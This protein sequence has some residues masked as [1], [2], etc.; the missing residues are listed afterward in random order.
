M[1]HA[2]T[3]A[4]SPAVAKTQEPQNKRKGRTQHPDRVWV[5]AETL[6]R[7]SGWIAEASERLQGV[8]ITRSDLV[9]YLVMSHADALSATE[10][11]EVEARY[12]DPLKHGLWAMGE[13]KAALA[14]GEKTTL[15]EILAARKPPASAIPRPRARKSDTSQNSTNPD[16]NA[17]KKSPTTEEGTLISVEKSSEQ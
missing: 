5:D 17:Q 4:T 6:N 9:N 7:L 8:T 3:S 2:V 15:S 12:F 13:L 14:R 10:M 16:K 11:K 1:D